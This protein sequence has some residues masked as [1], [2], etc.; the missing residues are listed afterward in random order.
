MKMTLEQLILNLNSDLSNIDFNHVMAVITDNYAYRPTEFR[1]GLSD[2]AVLNAAGSNEGSCKIFA[3]AKLNHLSE[4]QALA[5]FG[6]YYR[7]DVLQHPENDDHQNIRNFIQDGW[8]GIEFFGEPLTLK[9]T[10]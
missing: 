4:P 8:A 1:N 10:K 9:T 2:A 3:F 5:C 7:E 6:D